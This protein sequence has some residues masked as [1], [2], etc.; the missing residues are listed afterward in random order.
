MNQQASPRL[1]KPENYDEDIG[2]EIGRKEI[3]L[4]I[5]ST[6]LGPVV[7]SEER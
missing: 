5:E 2:F 7:G 1:Q 4:G 3:T 6:A